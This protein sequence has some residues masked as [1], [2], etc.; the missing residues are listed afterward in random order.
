VEEPRLMPVAFIWRDFADLR[1]AEL[2]ALLKL[3]C[4]V[5]VVEQNCAF[6][7]IDGKDPLARHL[8]CHDGA[9]LIG[10]LR[11]FV[12]GVAGDAARIGRVVVAPS[13]RGTG[14]GRRLMQAALDEIEVRHGTVPVALSA[15]LY[16]EAFYASLGF[17]R[18]SETY[19]ED[20]IPHCDMQRASS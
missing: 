14:L 8:L 4:D 9:D 19:L 13:A 20:G 16:L 6:P 15:Q 18:V 17:E 10:C 1:P 5:F 3:R 7:E 2:H 11:I 12:P